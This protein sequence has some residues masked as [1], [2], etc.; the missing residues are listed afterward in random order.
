MRIFKNI[1]KIRHKITGAMI[2]C[3]LIM[4]VLISSISIITNYYFIKKEINEK[5]TLLPRNY[6][7]NFNT[8]L[9]IIESSVNTLHQFI[10]ATVDIEKLG[11]SSN[12]YIKK[13]E[14]EIDSIIKEIAKTTNTIH[15]INTSSG[16]DA[17]YLTLNPEI[18]GEVH[19]IWYAN[20]T[21][22]GI[23][24]KLNP[25]PDPD[26]PY[27]QWFYPDNEDMS[28]Y[29]EPIQKRKGV[30]SEPY[31]E[32]DLG[33]I[34]ISY[35]E[36]IFKGDSLIGVVGMD[37]N[38]DAMKST[39]ENMKVYDT[40]Y[41]FLMDS[42]YDFLIHPTYKSE[43]NLKLIDNGKFKFMTEEMDK[44]NSGIINYTYKGKARMLGYSHLSNSWIIGFTAPISEIYSSLKKQIFLIIIAIF[45][46]IG[47]IILIALHVGKSISKPIVKIT[48]LIKNTAQFNFCDDNTL[49][50][51]VKNKDEI[52]IMAKEMFI[53]RKILKETG[54]DKAAILQR[55]SLQKEFP[56]PNKVNM[57][58]I[59]V[60]ANTVS[61]DFYRM[62][63]VK[64]NVVVGVIYD[65]S[66]KGVTAALNTSAFSVLFNES[67]LANQN[68][69]DILH[70]LNDKVADFLGEMYIAAS[71]FSFDFQKNIAKIAGAGINQ[72]IYCSKKD[73]YQKK[74]IKGPFLGMFENSIF[75]Q[76]IICFE[77]GDR[78]YFFTDG[79]EFLYGDMKIKDNYFK[80]AT[81]TE[82][83]NYTKKSIVEMQNNVK[84][85]KDD[86]TL[87]ALEIKQM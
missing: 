43:D 39:I 69:V 4:A 46:S 2:F 49:D 13:Y 37:I 15:G 12:E 56:L 45:L 18:M 22:N 75:D 85:I 19:E 25:D 8:D 23:L 47:S 3:S 29:Y 66:G 59:Y 78:F 54:V 27:I 77:P 30:W 87:L 31:E 32:V 53:M 40:G 16:V 9:K 79:L 60:P 24:K 72:F 44:K 84:V 42:H 11:E 64:D 81:I 57:E 74:D 7:N 35:T 58:M 10:S 73:F 14:M 36:P 70:D 41:V 52:G 6:S 67:V 76:Q 33:I 1:K 26:D 5:L 51:L 82:L 50:L 17:V 61:G 28:W 80:T 55:Q 62:Q 20:E 38:I 34:V 63:I 68:P 65:V 71:C 48:Q 83:K 86:C 21:G